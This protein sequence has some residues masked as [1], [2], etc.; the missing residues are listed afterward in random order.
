MFQI[1]LSLFRRKSSYLEGANK[2]LTFSLSL[3]IYIYLYLLDIFIHSRHVCIYTFLLY[4]GIYMHIYIY[5]YINSFLSNFIFKM[6]LYILFQ[7]LLFFS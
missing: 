1:T 2:T 6:F 5:F 7:C 3:S 4:K